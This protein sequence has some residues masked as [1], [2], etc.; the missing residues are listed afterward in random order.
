MKSLGIYHS[1]K[2]YVKKQEAVT[3]YFEMTWLANLWT[4]I[5]TFGKYVN[6]GMTQKVGIKLYKLAS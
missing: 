2:K 4:S 6:A 3:S 1:H 5:P